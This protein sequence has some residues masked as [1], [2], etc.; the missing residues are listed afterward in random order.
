VIIE[1]TY[2]F[3]LWWY[4]LSDYIF[5]TYILPEAY[6]MERSWIANFELKYPVD[7]DGT[8]DQTLSDSKIIKCMYF[9]LT[10]LS[11][12]GYGDLYPLSMAEKGIGIIYQMLGTIIFSIVMNA[13]LE[14]I[15]PGGDNYLRDN[16]I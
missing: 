2:I 3:G 9:V 10:T 12:V 6:P 8:D 4:R 5:P 14:I 13:L 1:V 7:Y 11:T 16:E 15:L